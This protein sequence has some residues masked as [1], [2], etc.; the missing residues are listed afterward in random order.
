VLVN[1]NNNNAPL[2][3]MTTGAS[4]RFVM[5]WATGTATGILPGGDSE[6]PISP[7]YSN[8]VPLWLKGEQ[9]PLLEG[10]AAQQAA[11]IRWRFMS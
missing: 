4:W 10:T 2:S 3:V 1:G 9:L 7:W 5:N 8:G 11:T 6:D